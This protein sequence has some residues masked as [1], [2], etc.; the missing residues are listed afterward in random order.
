MR[1]MGTVE[2][3]TREGEIEIAKRI[4][5]GLKH[6]IQAI[7][8]CPTTI[9]Q[10]LELVDKGLNDEIRIDDIID[11][12]I[13]PNAVEEVAQPPVEV[14]EE[15]ELEDAEETEEE[16]EDA[17]GS[18]VSAANLELLKGQAREHFE[19]VREMYALMV[20]SLQKRR[21]ARQGLSKSAT[22]HRRPVPEHP[23]FGT[24]G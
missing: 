10:I 20:A 23:L 21:R 17:D 2:L 19:V 8:A 7:S 12:F 9:T 11:G 3:L 5:D 15:E 1:E 18:A 16:D 13:D 22:R 4:E 6:M 14:V 24:P